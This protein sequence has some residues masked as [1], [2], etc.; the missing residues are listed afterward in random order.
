M[1]SSRKLCTKAVEDSC[2]QGERRQLCVWAAAEDRAQV[3]REG[4]VHMGSRT[5][6]GTWA[7]H[8]TSG[9]QGQE[10]G[11]GEGYLVKLSTGRGNT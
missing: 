3:Q 10:V 7:L 9:T 5:E 8:G 1:C 4:E 6:L 11:R 2:V